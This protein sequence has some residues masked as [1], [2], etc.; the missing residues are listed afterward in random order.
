ME[1]PNAIP[2][3]AAVFFCV[4]CD[5]PFTKGG[6]TSPGHVIFRLNSVRQNHSTSDTQLI[7]ANLKAVRDLGPVEH[8][9]HPRSNAITAPRASNVLA[10]V[11]AANMTHQGLAKD[12]QQTTVYLKYQE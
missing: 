8:V 11:S 10:K 9:M 1:P 6:S 5:K 7:A 2:L 3:T 4:L 12:R